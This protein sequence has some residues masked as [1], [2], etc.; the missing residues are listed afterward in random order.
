L[1]DWAVEKYSERLHESTGTHDYTTEIKPFFDAI[2]EYYDLT[3]ME[4]F[5]SEA[6]ADDDPGD[7]TSH[8]YRGGMVAGKLRI[9]HECCDHKLKNMGQCFQ[10]QKEAGFEEAVLNTWPVRLEHILEAG[11]EA[12]KDVGIIGFAKGALDK[13][14]TSCYQAIFMDEGL[15]QRLIRGG[16]YSEALYID[17][18]GLAHQA[19]VMPGLTAEERP[20]RLYLFSFMNFCIWG[21]VI[22]R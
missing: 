20:A 3:V 16:H 2:R 14:K 4:C 12:P 1:A 18:V 10:N 13:Q 22:C 19:W 7:L 9:L 6:A 21:A 15:V 11:R 5:R 8:F 17:I